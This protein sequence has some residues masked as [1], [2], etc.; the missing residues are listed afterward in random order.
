MTPGVSSVRTRNLLVAAVIGALA[1][2][3][4]AALH[5]DTL[6][7]QTLVS[8]GGALIAAA[9]FA[10][11]AVPRD[12]WATH[13]QSHGVVGVF[14]KRHGEI[15]D[16]EWQALLT[17]AKDHFRVLGGSNHGYVGDEG[18]LWQTTYRALFHQAITERHVRV[19]IMWPR[20]D[21]Q[22]AARAEK[23]EG[24]RARVDALEAMGFF[25]DLKS[26][27]DASMQDQL[28]LKEYDDPPSC[29]LVWADDIIV[30]SH[31]LPGRRHLD[32]PGVVLQNRTKTWRHQLPL[33]NAPHEDSMAGVY[34]NTY[35]QV[36]KRATTREINRDRLDELEKKKFPRAL[37]SEAQVRK[38]ST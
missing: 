24:R 1:V 16:A 11:L 38:A 27:L 28:L 35:E 2:A 13:L 25:Y 19:E 7:G 21:A 12:E 4:G 33:V 5:V 20:L 26:S 14:A 6:T 31:Y 10:W 37:P 9:A 29:G 15:S 34:A 17:K 36:A 22:G 8:I 3:L 32:S 30:V 18:A 23:E